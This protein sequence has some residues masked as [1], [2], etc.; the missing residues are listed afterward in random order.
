LPIGYVIRPARRT[1][2]F[3]L[4]RELEEQVAAYLER[5]LD[6]LLE[7]CQGYFKELSQKR[8]LQT[9]GVYLS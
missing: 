7:S 8:A 2:Q 5:G 1:A 6:A 4:W 9:A 3:R